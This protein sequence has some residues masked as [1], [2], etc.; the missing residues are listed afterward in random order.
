MYKAKVNVTLR[1][2]ILD[3]KGKAAHHALQNL[4]LTNIEGV[5]IG[6]L[7]E[8]DVQANSEEEARGIVESACSKL[9]A[10]EVMEDFDIQFE[11]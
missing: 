11:S 2:S 3:P 5:R 9:L 6:K 7:I 1:P 4:G 8:I 10:N